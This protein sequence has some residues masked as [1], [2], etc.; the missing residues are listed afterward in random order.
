MLSVLERKQVAEI[1]VI[2]RE[3][4]DRLIRSYQLAI[5]VKR[6]ATRME[7]ELHTLQWQ[8]QGASYRLSFCVFS[9]EHNPVLNGTRC[10]ECTLLVILEMFTFKVL[11]FS[12]ILLLYQDTFGFP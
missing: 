8:F 12:V 10:D 9:V 3:L 11:K 7:V 4:W 5:Y 1:L 6:S 2:T